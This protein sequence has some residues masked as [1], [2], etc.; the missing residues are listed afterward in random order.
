MTILISADVETSGPVPGLGDLVSFGLVVIEPGL[1]RTFRS[2]LM[3]AEHRQHE[4]ERYRI[5]GCTREGHE[6]AV[7]TIASVMRRME[8]WFEDVLATS[9]NGRCLLVS[10]NPGYDFMWLATESHLKLGHAQF[11]HSAR[12]IG[13]VWAGL[14]GKPRDTRGWKDLIVTPHDHDPVNDAMGVAEAWLAMWAMHGGTKEALLAGVPKPKI[15]D[16]IP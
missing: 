14:V 1:T 6:N 15:L 3:R 5:I 13:D 7:Q 12:R 16:P 9:R 2:G 4:K 10:D 8:L 11:G